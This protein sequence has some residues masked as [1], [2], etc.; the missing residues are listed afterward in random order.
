M[1]KEPTHYIVSD[2]DYTIKVMYYTVC[3]ATF[4]MYTRYAEYLTDNA[5]F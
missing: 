5:L 4:E 3:I 2:I 1:R